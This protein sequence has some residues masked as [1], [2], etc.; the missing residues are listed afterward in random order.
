MEWKIAEINYYSVHNMLLEY[1][2][3]EASI[4]QG[5]F[6][7]EVDAN[8]KFET[9]L[10][11]MTSIALGTNSIFK[12]DECNELWCKYFCQQNMEDYIIRVEDRDVE[13]LDLKGFFRKWMNIFQMTY[14]KYK[15]ILDAFT[16][17]KAHLLDKLENVTVATLNDT[18]QDGGDFSDDEHMTEYRKATTTV[19]PEPI[20]RRLNDLNTMWENVMWKWSA[21]FRGLIIYE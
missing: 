4:P 14:P 16:T 18:P 10:T 13:D 3:N 21:H 2:E 7:G 8:T 19:D 6:T 15:P 5:Y 20:I 17:E 9:V 1:F 12:G 11:G